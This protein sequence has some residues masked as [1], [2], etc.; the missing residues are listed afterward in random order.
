MEC[1][2][3]WFDRLKHNSSVDLD[4]SDLEFFKKKLKFA[5]AGEKSVP[6]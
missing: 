2:V 6:Y 4:V 3:L 1:S 5:K